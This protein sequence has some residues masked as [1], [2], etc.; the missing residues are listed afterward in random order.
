MR[1]WR[2]VTENIYKCDLNEKLAAI[3]DLAYDLERKRLAIEHALLDTSTKCQVKSVEDD[4][5]KAMWGRIHILIQQDA[6]H[7]RV[8]AN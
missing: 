2:P 3:G 5:E 4:L 7:A 6:L 8:G 1:G